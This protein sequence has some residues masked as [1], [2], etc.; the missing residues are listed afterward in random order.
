MGTFV[1]TFSTGSN[2]L[3]GF[4][5]GRKIMTV[6]AFVLV[7]ATQLTLHS[8]V[9]QCESYEIRPKLWDYK[10][11]YEIGYEVAKATNCN[12]D[13]VNANV[14]VN[15]NVNVNI[16]DDDDDD[17]GADGY[18]INPKEPILLLN[19]FG[20]GSFHQ[21]RLVH[22]LLTNENH[23][24]QQTVYCIDYLG[25]GRSWPKVCQDGL[26]ENEKDLQ[27]SADTWCEQIIDFIEAIVLPSSQDESSTNGSETATRVH[28]VGNSVGGHLAAHIAVRRPDLVASL[29]LLNPTPVW[30]SKLP[31]WNG[32][33]PA[34]AIPKAVGRYL[35][36][37]IRDLKTIEQFLTA[38]YSRREAFTDELMHQIR[39]CTLGNGGHAAFASIMWSPPLVS[40]SRTEHGDETAN[41]N[42]QRGDFYDCLKN[43]P[44]DV[45]LVFGKDDPWCK[46]AF[47]KRMLLALEERVGIHQHNNN[48][49]DSSSS[50]P[51]HH[52]YV[53]ISNSGH[54]PNHECPRAVGYLV[55]Q[56]VDVDCKETDRSATPPQKPLSFAE[57]WGEMSVRERN[58]SDIQVGW[59]DKIVTAMM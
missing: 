48:N 52:R 8:S 55:N 30:G 13:D 38:T 3:R 20:V 17:D 58:R 25:Q 43:V 4:A 14:N 6:L 39:G 51:F 16:N 23:H 28:L 47:A 37:R 36:D 18:G 45:L 46:P 34:P 12:S 35:F 29:C 24:P 21:H 44:C 54:C 56:W 22:E 40:V 49:K 41:L 1:F 9:G 2:Q 53:E 5:F 15:V 32:H 57:E 33:L 50:S 42:G 27:Y 10:S 11:R 19:G 59:K 31:G 26:G 7:V